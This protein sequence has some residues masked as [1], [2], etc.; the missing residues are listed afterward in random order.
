MDW[1]KKNVNIKSYLFLTLV[2]II[3]VELFFAKSRSE[4]SVFAFITIASVLNQLML[5]VGLGILFK[6]RE[7]KP[8]LGDMTKVFFLMLT[9]TG[10]LAVAFYMGILL[11]KDRIIIALFIYIVQLAN[12]FFSIKKKQ[13]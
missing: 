11:I 10:I 3:I 7:T 8:S 12:L 5:V 13:S 6:F 2:T 1:L 9:K 4:V